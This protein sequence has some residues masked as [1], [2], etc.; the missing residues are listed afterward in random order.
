MNVFEIVVKCITWVNYAIGYNATI[1]EKKRIKTFLENAFAYTLPER[2]ANKLVTFHYRLNY[3]NYVIRMSKVDD[4]EEEIRDEDETLF[5]I[6]K[7]AVMDDN[8]CKIVNEDNYVTIMKCSE[9]IETA[10]NK[11]LVLGLYI[12]GIMEILNV[13]VFSD[14]EKGKED[15]LKCARWNHLPSMVCLSYIAFIEENYEESLYWLEMIKNINK[16]YISEE[17]EK[18]YNLIREKFDDDKY[19]EITEN[20]DFGIKIGKILYDDSLDEK[21]KLEIVNNTISDIIYSKLFTVSEIERLLYANSNV[22]WMIIS[23]IVKNITSDN[24]N[25]PELIDV[26]VNEEQHQVLNLIKESIFSENPKP[27]IINSSDDI[28]SN[29]MTKKIEEYIKNYHTEI[30]D[31]GQ[32][33]YQ[34]YLKDTAV[35][36]NPFYRGVTMSKGNKFFIIYKNFDNIDNKAIYCLNIINPNKEYF[37]E[38]LK[39]EVPKSKMISI[40]LTQNVEKLPLSLLSISSVVNM[41]SLEKTE[42]VDSIKEY[43]LY[44]KAKANRENV[45]ISEEAME[46]LATMPDKVVYKVLNKILN[47]NSSDIDTNKEIDLETIKKII[48]RKGKSSIGFAVSD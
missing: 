2:P 46:Y 12:K 37:F 33:Y 39:I 28:N 6:I 30:I 21:I 42:K 41:K 19:Q 11:G 45:Q 34:E 27:I 31:L 20:V 22:E 10:A 24:E 25:Q 32:L 23:D 5:G 38:D 15:L 8:N 3:L 44:E 29:I 13:S 17:L 4:G 36:A 47:E 9:Q 1:G 40:I 43:F 48:S 14:Y 16:I 18:R 26:K 7:E 35:S